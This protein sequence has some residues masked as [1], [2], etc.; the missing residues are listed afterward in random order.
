MEN[1]F[2]WFN[3]NLEW[4]FD[5]IGV[6]LLSTLLGFFVKKKMDEKKNIKIS[7]NNKKDSINIQNNYIGGDKN[8]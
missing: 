6:F 8:E 2:G 5:G 3:N 7:Q 4:I 1:F